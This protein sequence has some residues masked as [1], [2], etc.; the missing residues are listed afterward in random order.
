MWPNEVAQIK[1]L[2]PLKREKLDRI[3]FGSCPTQSQFLFFWNAFA[4]LE[5]DWFWSYPAGRLSNLPAIQRRIGDI[6][7]LTVFL[8]LTHALPDY[9]TTYWPY[10]SNC[11][12]FLLS[13]TAAFSGMLKQKLRFLF[14]EWCVL[15]SFTRSLSVTLRIRTSLD[16]ISV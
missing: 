14:E 10:Y 1:S 3:G 9:H 12:K 11:L 8:E 7:D 5:L 16:L 6:F 2:T 4:R 15:V 13:M